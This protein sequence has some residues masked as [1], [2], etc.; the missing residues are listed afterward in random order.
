MSTKVNNVY[1]MASQVISFRL[2]EVETEALE[3]QKLEGESLNQTAQRLLKEVLGVP[4]GRIVSTAP[5]RPENIPGLEKF[6]LRVI[7]QHE[8]DLVGETIA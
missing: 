2:S 7:A 4:V 3:A 1:I 5:L 6:I 8:A